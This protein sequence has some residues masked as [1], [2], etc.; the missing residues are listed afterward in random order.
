MKFENDNFDELYEKKI[1]IPYVV[2]TQTPL[3]VDL[4]II[5]IVKEMKKVRKK[6]V[7]FLFF[8]V[9]KTILITPIEVIN[10]KG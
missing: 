9:N 6:N 1:W 2:I 4:Y 10:S 3:I 8:N 5:G 7:Y